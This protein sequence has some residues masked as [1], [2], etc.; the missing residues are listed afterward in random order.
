[1]KVAVLGANGYIG[2]YLTAS[3]AM[4]LL[5]VI[6]VTRQTVDLT[7]YQ[8]VRSWLQLVKPNTII[9][10]ATATG[11]F[12][13]T[14]FVYQDVQNNLDI[15]MNFYNNSDLFD[16]FINVGSG[17]EFDRT[18]DINSANEHDIFLKQPKDS[19][20]YSKNIIARLAA[21]K[22]NF[23]T[24]RLFGCFNRSEPNH[25]LFQKFIKQ[26]SVDIID[27][28]VDYISLDDFCIVVK[29]YLNNN[30]HKDVNCVYP[31]KYLLSE[32]FSL[33][34]ELHHIKTDLTI[35]G[36]ASNNYTG[37]ANQLSQLNFPLRGFIQG[38]KDYI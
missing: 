6:P 12:Q 15:F 21:K 38:L 32:I 27:R 25:R 31:Q 1:M 28:Y 2:K 19:Y 17:A 18:T 23:V 34:Q 11:R 36:T 9:N 5:T 8:Q 7:N 33:F 29:Q 22:E 4:D 13:T 20:G 16:Q 10:C 35:V 26:S 37:C 14:D 3:L 24:L 30:I